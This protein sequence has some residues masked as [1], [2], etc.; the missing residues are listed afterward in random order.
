MEEFESM[1]MEDG[2]MLAAFGIGVFLFIIAAYLLIGFCY[3]KLFQKAG[4]PL[5]A[6]FVPVYNTI[7]L[8]EIVGRPA[9]WV[10]LILFPITAII[11][12]PAVLIDLSKS[13]GKNDSVWQAAMV[14]FALFLIP[15][16]A[17]SSEFKYVGPA[18]AG[19]GSGT[20]L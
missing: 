5:W 6:G 11:A 20:G 8:L 17:F 1:P 18:A 16:M 3:G 14:S 7:V 15:V 10:V 12:L 2:G 4:K 19:D 13:F 9:W